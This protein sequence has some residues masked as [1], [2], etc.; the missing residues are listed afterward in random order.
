MY[1]QKEK[2]KENKSCAV[3]NS[4]DQKKSSDKQGLGFIDNRVK[5]IQQRNLQKV[6]NNISSIVQNKSMV[7]VVQ[8]VN[9]VPALNLQVPTDPVFRRAGYVDEAIDNLLADI[10]LHKTRSILIQ[11]RKMVAIAKYRR[12]QEDT[13]KQALANAIELVEPIVQA[14]PREGARG[15]G[16]ML[17]N[18]RD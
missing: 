15:I 14:L 4:V 2:P 12:N 10:Q 16:Q 1:E 17:Q 5:S 9:G 7:D 11:A 18:A 8:R 13:R 6:S 3:A